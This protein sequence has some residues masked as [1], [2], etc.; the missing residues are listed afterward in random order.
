MKL[1]GPL[2]KL[3]EDLYAIE[4]ANF[5][6]EVD[7]SKFEESECSTTSARIIASEFDWDKSRLGDEYWRPIHDRLS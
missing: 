6:K 7:I 3:Q 4:F 1:T 2:K 5:C